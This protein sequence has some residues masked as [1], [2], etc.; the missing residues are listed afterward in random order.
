MPFDKRCLECTNRVYTELLE[1]IPLTDSQKETF[2]GYL[3]TLLARGDNYSIQYIVHDLRLKLK[4]I[5][6]INDPYYS[7]KKES[8]RVALG[9]YLNWKGKVERSPDPFML[10]L[11]LALAGNIM[12]Y[13]ASSD[14]SIHHTIEKVVTSDFAIDHTTSLRKRL[15]EAKTILYIGDNAG[16]IVFDKLFIETIRHPRLTYAVRGGPAVN[17]ATLDDAAEVKMQRVAKVITTGY[18]AP[19]IFLEKSGKQFLGKFNS[20]DLIISKGQGNLEGLLPLKD[21]RIFFLLM[22]KCDVF[23]DYFNVPKGSFLVYNSGLKK[24]IALRHNSP[25]LEVRQL[26]DG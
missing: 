26:A 17:D 24:E 11:R 12:D 7:E 3:K 19:T 20:A 4:T 9:L 15:A 16:E 21:N 5:S 2:D 22:A 8:N 13:G 18:D 25:K 10:A 1:K 14:F 6:G 23:A